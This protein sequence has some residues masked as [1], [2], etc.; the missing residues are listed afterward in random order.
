MNLPTTNLP[1]I[2]INMKQTGL[3]PSLYV[4]R[5]TNHLQE[6]KGTIDSVRILAATVFCIKIDMKSRMNSS[7]FVRTVARMHE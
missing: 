4:L 5:D 6:L 2:G 1:C 3:W 7:P